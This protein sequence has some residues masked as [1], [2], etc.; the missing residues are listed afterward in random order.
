[1]CS[2]DLGGS[3][4]VLVADFTDMVERTDIHGIGYALAMAAAAQRVL[5][6]VFATQGG[7]QVKTVADTLFVVFASP[8]AALAA[9][10][11]GMR[12]LD[13][14]N[15]GRTGV[16]HHGQQNEPILGCFGLGF[17]DALVIPGRDLFG[18]EVNR[19]FVLGEDVAKGGEVLMTE[20]F[21]RA[22]G[23]LPEGVGAFTAPGDREGEAGFHFHVV[24]D[25][26]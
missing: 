11:N 17:G 24:A 20:A 25:Y 19:A 5:T 22:L 18:A 2:F 15:A 26:R 21:R 23:G 10:L 14:F 6:P 8:Q 4:A 16:L 12:A 1:M 13:A 9:A 3:A 7:V